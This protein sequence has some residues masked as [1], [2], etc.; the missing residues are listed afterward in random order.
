MFRGCTCANIYADRFDTSF[1]TSMR[2][3]FQLI[4]FVQYIFVDNQLD[5]EVKGKT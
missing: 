5:G 1:I 3:M 2:A 4:P